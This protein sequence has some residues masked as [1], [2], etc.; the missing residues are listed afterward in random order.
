M[1]RLRADTARLQLGWY[2][3]VVVNAYV[4]E[5]GAEGGRG[6]GDVTLVDTGLRYNRRSLPAELRAAGYAPG[7]VDRI[8]LTHYDLDHVGGVGRFDCPVYLGERDVDLVRG[9]WSPPAGHPKGAF[10]RVARRLVDL[11]DADLRPVADGDRI[12]GFTAYHTPGHNPGHTAFVRDGV[13][14]VGD[15]LW[16]TDGEL[17]TPF[18]G[19]SYDMAELRRSVRGF[20]AAVGPLEAICPGHGIPFVRAGSARLDSLVDRL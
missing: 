9:A 4:H 13:A 17:T 5:T 20:A 8:L 10:H 14:F 11:D 3:P 2:E 15:L 12:A 18:W 16:E 1:E 19:D 7:D 6:T